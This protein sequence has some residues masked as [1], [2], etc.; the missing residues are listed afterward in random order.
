MSDF[1]HGDA[2]CSEALARLFEFLDS[3]ISE[4]DADRIRLH[5]ADCEGCFHEYDIEHH[6]KALVRRSC[7]ETAP[8]ELHMRIREQII[9]LRDRRP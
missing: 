2:D 7:S 5:L 4:V 9:V 1:G 8:A 6:L 3:E